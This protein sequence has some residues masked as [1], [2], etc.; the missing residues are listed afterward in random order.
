MFSNKGYRWKL[1]GAL[2]LI[3]AL[4]VLAA[5]RGDSINPPLWRC[6]VEPA[7]W[8]GTVLWIPS[9][10]ITAVRGADFEIEAAGVRIRVDGAAPAGAGQGLTLY[11]VF[12]AD[13][14]RFELQR[15][16]VFAPR[17]HLRWLMEAVSV[18]VLLAA[19]A[20]FARH[21]LIRPKVLQFEGSD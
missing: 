14:P 11:G 4:G 12:R 21:F 20:N 13:G 9:A 10:Q 1:G 3:A 8:D 7:R 5:W 15:S 19:M 18:L 17:V 6:V 2:T 16:R